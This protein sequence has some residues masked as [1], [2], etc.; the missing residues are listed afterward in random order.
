[1][2]MKRF[3]N[4]FLA[5]VVLMLGACLF[6]GCS[7]DAMES[8]QKDSVEIVDPYKA[9]L[10]LRLG[11]ETPETR[12][13][14]SESDGAMKTTWEVGESVIVN[15]SPGT[16][17]YSA[18]FS[19]QSGAGTSTGTFAGTINI[20][21][22]NAWTIYY[23]KSI[24]YEGN[25]L[26]FSYKGQTQKGNGNKDHIKQF[27]T[28]RYSLTDGE[29]ITFDAAG[30]NFSGSGLQES[31]CMKF[32]LSG[33]TSIT[34]VNISLVYINPQGAY[35]DCF[36]THNYLDTWWSG[37]YRADGE[38]SYKMDLAL[39]DF[40]ATTS[41][42]AYMMMSN[43]PALVKK[44]GKLRVY[45]TASDGNR[46]Y[47]D[48]TIAADA[49]IDGGKLHTITCTEW[50]KVGNIDGFDNPDVG[51]T[52]LQSK[53][54]GTGTDI[55]IMGDGFAGTNDNFGSNGNN[56]KYDEIMRKAYDDFFSVEP[57]KKF[58][59]YFNVYYINAVSAE[60]HDAVPYNDGGTNG[61]TNGDAKTVFN[62]KFTPGSTNITG[63]DIMAQ[64][65]AKQ[66]IRTKGNNGNPVEDEAEVERRAGTALVMVMTNVACHAG[67]CSV[68]SV[69]GDDYCKAPSYAYTA[70]GTD[71]EKRRWTTIHE[72]GGH[73][74]GKLADE[75]GGKYFTS[76]S[77]AIWNDLNTCHGIGMYRNV[78]K[79]WNPEAL[80]NNQKYSARWSGLGAQTTIDKSNVYWKDLI[81]SYATEPDK[82]GVF[83]GGW[84]YDELFCRPTENSVMRNQFA[85]NGKFFNAISRWAIW[86][87][88]MR[89]ST[90]LYDDTTFEN[91]VEDFKSV[92]P[93]I[94][95]Q[96]S[97]E[98]IS[99]KSSGEIID[100]N[101]HKP[102]APP[103]VKQGRW[104]NG[105]F[106][107]E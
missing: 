40:S 11:G 32:N 96:S 94:T 75:Y 3:Q 93:G 18:E 79:Y 92:D 44:D 60:D 5:A 6:A 23:P 28:I 24:K 14:Y 38:S 50:Q 74:F 81:T 91:T 16:T 21:S 36:K 53:S 46:Y 20:G 87:R 101:G 61:A 63:N 33:L 45:V 39:E 10:V 68:Y 73:G 82:L 22:S 34:P 29:Y 83:A 70:L 13:N 52:V 27:H 12:L 1:M 55:I 107:I 2:I 103:V 95:I 72:A 71:E 77:T 42:T 86:Y 41:I 19:L 97:S 105:K 49:T 8:S 56:G 59:P 64:Q 76:F 26:A 35:E 58:K 43:W 69:S 37:S 25:W 98:T 90:K 15:P 51:V 78:D 47:C 57:F 17:D 102:L 48:K 66:A 80:F 7:E 4:Y 31:A 89:L 54:S 106:V 30:I 100:S 9:T 84:T 99:V 67:T 85:E 62:T 65:Y 104:E 88:L